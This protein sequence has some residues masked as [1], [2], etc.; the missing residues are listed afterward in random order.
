MSHLRS[1]FF[2]PLTKRW[3][4][5]VIL[6][7]MI[8]ACGD[9]ISRRDGPPSRF[10]DVSRIPNAIPKIEPRSKS[11]NASS[12]VVMGK[13]Y[14]VMGT[15]RGYDKTGVASWY[16]K[17]FH[18]RRTSNGEIFDM[19]AM[20]AAHTTLPLPTYVEVTNLSNRQKIIVRI[21]DRG[22]FHGNRIIDLSYVAAK[23]LGIVATGTARV[24]IRAIGQQARDAKGKN[25]QASLGGS[26]AK[27][28]QRYFD[29]PA[30]YLQIGAFTQRNN[31]QRLVSKLL[32]IVSDPVY[33][34]AAPSELGVVHRVWIGPFDSRFGVEKLEIRLTHD[35][36]KDTRIVA[37]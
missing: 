28:K 36:I 35:G 20:T 8:P 14:Y 7:V 3:F 16:G 34:Q 22:P 10:I 11:G 6:I 25:M 27:I 23:K 31:A 21:N 13:R 19:Y 1:L 26:M 4:V 32:S 24:R 30:F 17:L 12:Y 18:G 29:A 9:F 37:K 2:C 33:I 5:T 15:S